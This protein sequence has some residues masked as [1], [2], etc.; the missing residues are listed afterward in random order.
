MLWKN[1]MNYMLAKKGV[2]V[3]FIIAFLSAPTLLFAQGGDYT[4]ESL[5]GRIIDL[6]INPLIMLFMVLGTAFFLWGI[7]EFL[8]NPDNEE[9]RKSGK[10]HM[11]WGIIGL[12]LMVSVWGIIRVLCDFFQTCEIIGI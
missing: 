12:F 5:V 8:M 7:I 11:M 4:I 10:K 2:F 3:F 1:Y 6:I 9:K